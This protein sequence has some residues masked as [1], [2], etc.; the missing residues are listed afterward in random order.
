MRRAQAVRVAIVVGVV[1]S[2][3]AALMLL[4]LLAAKLTAEHLARV[5]GQELGELSHD[6]PLWH[7]KF[8]TAED[9]VAGRA[10]GQARVQRAA[11]G[12]TV[13]STDGTAFELG[14]P[15]QHGLD[16]RHWPLLRLQFGEPVAARLALIWQAAS[17]PA[18]V[19]EPT[20]QTPGGSEVIDLRALSAH[21]PGSSTRCELPTSA[22]ML[23]LRLTLPAGQSLHLLGASLLAPDSALMGM[24]TPLIAPSNPGEVK[25]WL[26]ALGQ[27]G[28]APLV[29][30][31]PAASAEAQLAWRDR[32]VAVRP[33][34]LVL[35]HGA[36][37]IAVA[38][39]EVPVWAR[40]LTCLIYLALLA[41]AAWRPVAGKRGLLLELVACLAGPLWLIAG[42]QL[43]IHPSP[44]ALTAFAGAIV[45][46]A[47]TQRRRP[48][49]FRWVGFWRLPGWWLPLLALPV[50]VLLCLTL[51][52]RFEAL[53]P[54][55]VLLYLAWALL[56]QWLILV[57][58]MGRLER[59]LPGKAPSVLLAALT[60]ALLHT[61]NGVLMQLCFVA[62]LGWAWCFLRHRALLPI[63]LA[64]AGCALI[65][66]SGLTGGLL[67]SLEVSTRFFS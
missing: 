50:A 49:V 65:I 60:F 43:G 53:L 37:L 55:H 38:S 19:A 24:E 29:H 34:A 48:F 10:F 28:G 6:Q 40:W 7:W 16:L 1:I 67:R 32:I 41:L 61:P 3:C 11:S 39:R 22:R 46:A 64:H 13:T 20:L 21:S 9:L 2:A 8:S 31:P 26:H 52:H 36:D 23:R 35:P 63:A 17:A 15:I 33:G 44:T 58:V 57:V 27:L 51:G 18:C 66:E 47:W 42:L 12:L 45:F 56:Q 62:E 5:A 59:L 4:H 54:R 30:L 25:H 14:L